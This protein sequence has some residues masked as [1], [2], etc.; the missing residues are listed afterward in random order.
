MG[1]IRTNGLKYGSFEGF[2]YVYGIPKENTMDEVIRTFP[3]ERLEGNSIAVLNNTDIGTV[4]VTAKVGDEVPL[5]VLDHIRH[6]F[7]EDCYEWFEFGNVR[8]FVSYL[9]KWNSKGKTQLYMSMAGSK[10][11]ARHAGLSVDNISDFATSMY[12][13]EATG[14]EFSKGLIKV[15]YKED[16]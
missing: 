3:V 16:K 13:S 2:D 8:D 7:Y 10:Y 11:Y 12:I 15:E 14:L 1:L 5:S 9:E 6:E 4:Y